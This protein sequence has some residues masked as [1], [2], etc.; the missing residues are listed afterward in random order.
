MKTPDDPSDDNL[1][2]LFSRLR[3]VPGAAD[4]ARVE[5]GFET[6]VL[7]RVRAENDRAPDGLR[8]FW[9]WSAVFGPA[10]IICAVLVIRDYNALNDDAFAALDGGVT[11][12]DIFN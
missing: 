5:N 3:D 10:A 1:S 6:R 9:R 2:E 4:P 11:L 12:L 8:W 7:A